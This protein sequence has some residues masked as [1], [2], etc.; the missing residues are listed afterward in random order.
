MAKALIIAEKPSVA[1]DIARALGKFEKHDDF[2]ENDRYIISSAIGHLVELS[3]PSEYT[4]KRGKWSFANLPI[5]PE[6]FE[7]KPIEKTEARFKLLKR[8]MRRNDVAELINACDAGREGE[9]IFRFIVKLSGVEKTVRRLWLQSMTQEAIREAF[10]HL[11]EDEALVPLAKAA[12]SRAES[13]WLVGI[14]A[15]RALTALNSRNGG[16]Q[17]T[18][19]GRV[20]TPTLTILVERESKIRGFQIRPYFEVHA[21]FEAAAGC[22]PGRW[23]DPNF[24]K[25]NDEDARAERLWEREKADAIQAK[26]GG[27][28]GTVISEDKK[29]ISQPPP[30]LFDLTSLQREVNGRYGF[31]ARR[32]LQIAQQ[33]YEKHKV[34]TY[35]RTDSRYLPKDNLLMVRSILG[36]FG[37]APYGQFAETALANDWVKANPRVFD[38]AKVSDHSAIIPTGHAP[39]GLDDDQ[40]KIYDLVSRRL[41]AAF[42]PAAKFETTTRITSVQAE[43]FKTEGRI[44]RAAGWM[45]VYG[46]AAASEAEVEDQLVPVTEN[47]TVQ[48]QECEV[49]ALETKPPP[50]FNEATLLSAMEGAGKLVED[51]ELKAALSAKGLGTPATRAAIIEGLIMDG[52]IIRQGRELMPTAKGI[53]LIQLLR[54]IGIAALCSPELTGEWEAKL[55]EMEHGGLR[56]STFMAQIREMTREI[57]EKARNFE[58][59]DIEGEFGELDAPCPKCGYHPLKEEFRTFRCPSCNYVFWKV[60]ASR[61]FDLEEVK[62]LLNERKIGPLEGFRSKLGRP[63]AATVV[64]GPEGKPEFD[65]R[66]EGSEEGQKPVDLS[67]LTPIHRCRVCEKGQVYEL[68]TAFAC[69]HAVDQSKQCTFRMG[70]VILQQPISA[71]QVVKLMANGQTDL[72]T[73]FISKKG[74]PFSAFLKLEGSKVGFVFPP[75]AE[76][77]KSVKPTRAR[78]KAIP[79]AGK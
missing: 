33:L 3:A 61:Q 53:A 37:E 8:L 58:G 57:V 42:F 34:L 48:V 26:C 65:F 63:F 56:R 55:R 31:S 16:F 14:N 62:T 52:Y 15:T 27:Q 73:R 29:P 59:A 43:L 23:F 75:R 21:N 20:Q 51:E 5:I 41:I 18:P 36:T 69:E 24:R 47:E 68:E 13:D 71:E 2:F 10:A 25:G 12:F 78:A 60:L 67:L 79:A 32:T 44:L 49:R 76:K 22:Y 66:A 64:L 28:Q 11:R 6:E 7:L 30:L 46:R 9:L 74:K 38:D 40:Q 39:R 72:L 1:N 19:A 77:G 4:V 45:A 54:G 70:K 17:L 35:P 50:R